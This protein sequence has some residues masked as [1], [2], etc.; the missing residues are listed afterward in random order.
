M[1]YDS[2]RFAKLEAENKA[3][4]A[5]VLAVAD[6]F[7]AIENR[8][9]EGGTLRSLCDMGGAID[10]LLGVPGGPGGAPWGDSA[11]ALRAIAG[12]AS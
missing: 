6:G 1:P 7:D 9:T 3:L 2:E 12:G 5:V 4:R 8:A 11:A 10:R